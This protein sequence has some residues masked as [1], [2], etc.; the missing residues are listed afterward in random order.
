LISGNIVQACGAKRLHQLHGILKSSPIWGV[1]L[2]LATFSVTG[3]PPFGSFVSEIWILTHSSE[4]GN[5]GIVCSLLVALA[6]ALV[7]VSTH[8]GRILF[9]GPKA[10]FAAFHPVRAS[11]IPTALMIGSLMLGLL[12]GPNVGVGF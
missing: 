6:I 7:A 9:G 12:I 10:N 1:L 3:M 2:T 5:W 4:S 8:V 11:I